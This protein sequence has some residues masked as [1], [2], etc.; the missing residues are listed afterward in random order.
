MG[1][2][3]LTVNNQTILVFGVVVVAVDQLFPLSIA[4]TKGLDRRDDPSDHFI[5]IDQGELQTKI[6]VIQV[7]LP[8]RAEDWEAEMTFAGL[9]SCS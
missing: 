7:V 9:P 1:C 3:P 6:Q 2:P 5:A 4:M 8:F